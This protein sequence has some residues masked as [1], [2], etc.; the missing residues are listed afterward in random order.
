MVK[1][2]E[3]TDEDL[4]KPQPGP[5]DNENDWDDT[6]DDGTN[7][8]FPKLSSMKLS[9][10]CGK[11]ALSIVAHDTVGSDISEDDSTYSPEDET[12]LDRLIALRDIIPPST[13]KG[14]SHFFRTT[15]AYFGTGLLWGGKALWVVGSSALLLGVPWALAYAEEQQLIEMERDVKMQQTTSEVSHANTIGL[16]ISN[17]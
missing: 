13:R 14:V 10:P 3:V 17:N 4:T 9:R 5:V 12:L 8:P 6:D 7:I 16:R 15:Y 11:F 2:E 1:L